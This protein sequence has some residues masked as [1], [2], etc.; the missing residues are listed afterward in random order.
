MNDA[1]RRAAFVSWFNGSP[2]KGDRE[3]LIR[4]SGLT[5]GRISQLFD[6]DQQF[7]ERAA[8]SLADRLGLP[9]DFFSAPAQTTSNVAPSGMGATMIPLI[10]GVQAGAWC[11]AVEPLHAGND[12]EW[13]GTDYP[14]SKSAF[15]LEVKGVSMQPEF[16]PGDRIIVDPA[17]K[18]IPGDFV[19]AKNGEEEATFKKYRPQGVDASGESVFE[20]VALNEDYPSM[21]SDVTPM[22]IIGTMVEHRK[23]RRR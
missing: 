16:Q 15:A 23:Y 2:C 14:V 5:K 21:R 13:L 22:R 20:L 10:S 18:P 12:G 3:V 19:V 1:A 17:V 6:P 4:K 8:A 11:E 9:A 7:G